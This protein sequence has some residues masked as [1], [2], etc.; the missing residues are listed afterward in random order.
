LAQKAKIFKKKPKKPNLP[1]LGFFGQFWLF[2]QILAFLAN[3]GKFWLFLDFLDF[4][5][6]VAVCHFGGYICSQL[7]NIPKK[8]AHDGT[9][10][11]SPPPH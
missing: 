8:P 6:Q 7:R 10:C 1:E 3:F 4:L 11:L 9:L 2:G 5:E